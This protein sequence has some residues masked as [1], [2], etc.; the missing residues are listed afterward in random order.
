M[1]YKN[2]RFTSQLGD[3]TIE[4]KT[5][6]LA[7]LAG[8]AVIVKCGETELLATA[9]MSKSTREGIDFFPLT[10]DFEERLSSAGRIPGSFF[11]REGRPS[12][13]G[14]LMARLIDRPI[15]P[16]FPQD[17]R[18]DV[19]VIVTPLSMGDEVYADILGVIAASAALTISNIPFD[20]PVAAVRI[21]YIN[22]ELVVNPTI[23]QMKESTLN[24]RVAGSADAIIM[25]EAGADEI[26]ES[27]DG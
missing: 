4:I 8:G 1:C 25:V 21:G 12:E 24:L 11:R 22:G 27:L 26:D 16:L 2:F 9:T 5:G 23:S 7:R 15:R 19:Q 10:V 6:K 18:N 3:Q 13:E 14:I 17:M 20:G